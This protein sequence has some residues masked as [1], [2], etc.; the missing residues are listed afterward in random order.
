MSGRT[1]G[2]Y[3]KNFK[4]FPKNPLSIPRKITGGVFGQ[5]LLII[6][7]EISEGF[8]EGVP[9]SISESNH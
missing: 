4:G 6:F 2:G 5:F 8:S 7:N 3:L 9:E 1:S